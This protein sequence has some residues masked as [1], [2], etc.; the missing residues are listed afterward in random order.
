MTATNSDIHVQCPQCGLCFPEDPKH[1]G[2]AGSHYCQGSVLPNW[3]VQASGSQAM[4]YQS[5]LATATGLVGMQ[6][7]VVAGG[8]DYEGVVLLVSANAVSR[9]ILVG[10]TT[11]VT[12]DFAAAEIL[13]VHG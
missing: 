10:L 8:R 5:M 4:L 9:E 11:G 2:H 12:F 1:P 13:I 6:I 7:Q 3:Q